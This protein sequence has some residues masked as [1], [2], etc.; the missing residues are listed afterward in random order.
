[1]D[2]A[3][4]SQDT[5]GEARSHASRHFLPHAGH[6]RIERGDIIVSKGKSDTG[7]EL[8]GEGRANGWDRHKPAAPQPW[9]RR[10]N[11][12][13]QAYKAFAAFRDQIPSERTAV[14]AAQVVGISTQ[15][16]HRWSRR[17][18]WV[19]RASVF[20]SHIDELQLEQG[21]QARLE[22]YR[23]H[24]RIACKML[25][26]LERRLASLKASSLSP[27]EVTKWLKLGVEIERLARGE[28]KDSANIQVA[29][30]VEICFGNR[31]PAWLIP[32]TAESN[33]IEI[34]EN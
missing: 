18:S 33:E 26:K 17:H 5:E 13:S 9:E 8:V 12:S 16:A 7:L 34:K 30:S 11:E 21:I 14:K 6:K 15:L 2:K 23:R 31:K 22:M 1:M 10:S 32:P 3:K 28:S 20:D 24:A 19:S 25:E 29:S 4:G 27:D